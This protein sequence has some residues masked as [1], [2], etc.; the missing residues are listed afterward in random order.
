MILGLCLVAAF[1]RVIQLGGFGETEPWMN[2]A[3]EAVVEGSRIL[4][5][6]FV[7]GV[8]NIKKGLLQIGYLF[9]AQM[10]WRKHWS[11]T[12]K[13]IKM[14]WVY[15]SMNLIGFAAIAGVFNLLI[16]QLAYETAFFFR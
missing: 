9:S 2:P 7:L 6:L 12:K 13:N 11:N 3:L 14:N 10:E 16:D 8:A 5:F 15:L 4:M 1:V